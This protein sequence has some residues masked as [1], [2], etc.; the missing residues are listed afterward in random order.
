MES[1]YAT[2]GSSGHRAFCLES[3]STSICTTN[4]STNA[5]T[6]LRCVTIKLI[7]Y[8]AKLSAELSDDRRIYSWRHDDARWHEHHELLFQYDAATRKYDARQYDARQHDARELHDH[9]FQ[10]D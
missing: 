3:N 9:C 4:S 5:A 6:F 8:H 10:H 1:R 2:K 7:R